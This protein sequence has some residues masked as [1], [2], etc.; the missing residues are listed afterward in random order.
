[1]R[2]F[3]VV[4]PCHNAEATLAKCLEALLASDYPHDRFE[5]IVSDDGSADSS[6]EIARSLGVQTL[7]WNRATGPGG[8][9]NR[10]AQAAKYEHLLF[11]DS[12]VIVRPDTLRLFD[13]A[14]ERFP[15]A[16]VIQAIYAAGPYHTLFS[17]YQHLWFYY[18]YTLR[19]NYP[20][21]TFSSS[22]FA[23]SRKDFIEAGMLNPFLRTNED[24][25]FG[26]RLARLGK[27]AV[28]CTDIE[29]YHD[30]VFTLKGFV[31]RNFFVHNFILVRLTYG[32]QDVR[33]GNPEYDAPIKNLFLTAAF[34]LFCVLWPVSGWWPFGLA[35]AAAFA[36]QIGVNLPFLKFLTARVGAGRIV[37]LYGILL[38]DNT[39]K[40]AGIA[41]GLIDF[42]LRKKHRLITEYSKPVIGKQ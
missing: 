30:R 28:I 27:K 40:L 39:V 17:L 18:F 29:V 42:Y 25:E 23:V 12:D 14:A 41:R 26:Y 34:L 10:G 16:A 6:L 19:R 2:S 4:I 20:T 8:A 13:Q 15:D 33:S 24:T 38:L 35:A 1:M 3:S 7:P 36:W 5:I 9:R 37:P 31:K 11:F 21:L 22:C 32:M